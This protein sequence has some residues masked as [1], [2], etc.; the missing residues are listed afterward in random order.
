VPCVLIMEISD[1]GPNARARVQALAGACAAAENAEM[2]AKAGV[3]LIPDEWVDATSKGAQVIEL[4]RQ[5]VRLTTARPP[6]EPEVDH[7]TTG[8]AARL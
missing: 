2:Y 6:P 4:A 5:L 3:T 8:L 1:L 7:G